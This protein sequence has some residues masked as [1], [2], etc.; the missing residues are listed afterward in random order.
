[1][2]FQSYALWPHMTVAKNLALPL[3]IR[4][5]PKDKQKVLIAEA[6]DKV[7]LADLSGRYPHQ[8]SGGQQQRVALARRSSTPPP[9]FCSTSRCQTS[10]PSF[11]SRHAP[12]SSASRRISASPPSTSP[13]TRTRPSHSATESQS[14]RAET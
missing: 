5:V 11:G 13:T 6:L 7:G 3:N 1:M 12:G 14:W 10:T 9:C 4:K 8:L 2:V